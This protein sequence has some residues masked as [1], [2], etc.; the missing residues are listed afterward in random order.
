[1]KAFKKLVGLVLL[2]IFSSTALANKPST[3]RKPSQDATDEE[4]E[5]LESLRKAYQNDRP[6]KMASP[7]LQD[8]VQSEVGSE[9]EAA[10]RKR[11][12]E[13]IQ[14]TLPKL[15]VRQLQELE[16]LVKRLHRTK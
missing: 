9:S 4:M 16:A 11:Y 12:I 13:S 14:K 5:V 7:E 2:S 15:T 1:M 6:S 8:R 3:N 10:D